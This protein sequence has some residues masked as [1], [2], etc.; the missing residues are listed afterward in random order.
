[1]P[2]SQRAAALAVGETHYAAF[3]EL[4]HSVRTGQPGFERAFGVPLFDYFAHQRSSAESF[5]AALAELRSGTAEALLEAFDF[6]GAQTVVDVGGGT[7]GLL[8]MILTRHSELRGVLIDLPQ[9]IERAREQLRAARL[10]ERCA[11]VAGDFF[12]SVPPG[13]DVYVLRHIVHDWDDDRAARLL[14]N[15]RTAMHIRSK[16]LLVESI[17]PPGNEPAPGKFLDLVMLAL[18]GGRE[19]TEPEYESLLAAAGLRLSRVMPTAADVHLIEAS[20]EQGP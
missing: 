16:L 11:L 13:A 6:T 2:G 5:D 8:S 12:A 19:R 1:M 18:T 10:E 20:R 17:V 4:L 15:C 9:V 14:R 7:G 3:G